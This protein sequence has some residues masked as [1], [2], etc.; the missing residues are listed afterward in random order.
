MRP[1]TAAATERPRASSSHSFCSRH[2][3]GQS[4]SAVAI[5]ARRVRRTLTVAFVVSIAAVKVHLVG[6]HFTE[7]RDAPVAL[8]L[9][10]DAWIAIVSSLIIRFRLLVG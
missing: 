6:L 7:L 10:F 9:V 4:Q 2:W 1:A 5:P 3:R 8:R